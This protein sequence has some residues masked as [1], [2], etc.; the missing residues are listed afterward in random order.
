MVLLPKRERENKTNWNDFH[1]DLLGFDEKTAS[2]ETE[3][4]SETKVKNET[5]IK[6]EDV[7]ET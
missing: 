4:K 5:E 3:S 1:F 6:T 2:K 7:I